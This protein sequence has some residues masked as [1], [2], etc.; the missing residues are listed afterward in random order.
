MANSV[1]VRVGVAKTLGLLAGLAGFFLLPVLA[2]ET[3][4]LLRWGILFWYLNF[5][6]M[7]GL[8]GLIS[9]HPLFSGWRLDWW[10]RGLFL[11]AWLNFVLVFFA[12][13]D[14][15]QIMAVVMP[16]GG[17]LASPWAFALEGALLGL[18]IDGVASA[19]GGAGQADD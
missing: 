11:G 10:F 1:A 5:G 18:L 4:E 7:I 15:A 12:Y 19:L 17:L 16:E 9:R 6:A 2:P 8:M 13:D 14:F 3:P